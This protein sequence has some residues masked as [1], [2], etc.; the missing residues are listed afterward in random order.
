MKSLLQSAHEAASLDEQLLVLLEA[1]RK[2]RLAG[3]AA[4]IELVAARLPSRA[5]PKAPSTSEAQKR[6]LH[7]AAAQDPRDLEWL[8]KD[9]VT[10]RR[11]WSTERVAA[12]STWPDDPRIAPGL[13]ALI[14]ARPFSSEPHRPFWTATFR[15][16]GWR[17]DRTTLPTIELL[18]EGARGGVGNFDTY[19]ASKLLTLVGRIER[20]AALPEP[21]EDERAWL[22]AMSSA[23]AVPGEAAAKKTAEDFLAEIWASPLDDGPREV[24]ADWLLEHGDP[25]GELIALQ[26]ARARGAGTAEGAKRER[27]LL[28]EHAR[29]WMGPLE[30]A[31]QGNAFRFERGF[32]FTCK[33]AWRKLLATPGLVKHPAWAT[34]REYELDP[35][36]EQV[37]DAWLDH[38]IALGAKRR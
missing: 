21:T 22:D 19:V 26:I 34:V 18:R 27:A 23:L 13:L 6:W 2:R 36:G 20:D 5:P 4:I 10:H 12:L 30:P 35:S 38:M 11:E 28:A 16:I 24:Y 14:R 8:L 7:A 29:T 17:A 32:L 15:E 37:C 25:R 1:W 33:V 31:V 3:T 9:I